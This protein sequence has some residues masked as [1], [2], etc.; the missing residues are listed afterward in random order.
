MAK[1]DS[2]FLTNDAAG[3]AYQDKTVFFGFTSEA[4]AHGASTTLTQVFTVPAGLSGEIT[5]VGI[6]VVLP[7]VS[8]S[9]FVSGTVDATLRINSVA[10]CSTNPSIAM[11]GSAGQATRAATQ[12]TSGTASGL[13]TSA[14]VNAASNAFTAGDQIAVDMNARSVGSAAAGAAG[15]GLY[16]YVTFRYKSR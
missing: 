15:K 12:F 11:A 13:I 7:A 8:A 1:N 9:G 14:V 2:I 6:G 3:Y 10:V 5:D 16:G 4:S